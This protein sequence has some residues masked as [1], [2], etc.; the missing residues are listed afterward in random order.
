[1]RG[2]RLIPLLTLP[3]T[4][5]A[6]ALALAGARVAA[7]A[8]PKAPNKSA[9]DYHARYVT[10]VEGWLPVGG[11]DPRPAFD[12]STC[13]EVARLY[14]LFPAKDAIPPLSAPHFVSAAEAAWLDDRAPVLG[15]KIGSEAHCYPLAVL[16]WHSLAEDTIANL[17]V[18]VF[19]DPPSGLAVA[20]RMMSQS[21]PMG[22][23]GYGYEGIG[24]TYEVSSGRL[25]DMFAGR[26]LNVDV[27]KGFGA[28]DCEWL[29]LERMTWRQWRT[30]HGETLVL[31]RETGYSFDYS[32]DPY[33][34]A[35]LGPGGKVENYWTGDTLL[36]PDALRDKAQTLPDKD[37]VLGIIAGKEQW[38]VPLDA[39][40]D[41]K[42]VT[43]DTAV[44]E[45]TV[46]ARPA[47][48]WYYAE[49]ET[50]DRPRQVRMFWYAWKTRFPATKVYRKQ[51][52]I[53]TDG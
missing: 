22:L 7:P 21:R 50:G 42:T 46:H 36:A 13:P 29:P 20:R 37:F 45:V 44:G 51:E 16:N 15:L 12:V 39:L 52:A 26:W 38:A 19:F 1:M 11:N 31:S 2:P 43:L 18:Y 49:D 32:F 8:S 33:T 14:D 6:L 5:V 28:G 10:P 34:A 48:D 35:A 24:L 3:L 9:S 41:G 23:S 47:D 53:E 4:C 30:L 17:G 40:S 25:Y 27:S